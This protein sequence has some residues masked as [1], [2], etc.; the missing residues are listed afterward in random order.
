M[1]DL[2]V[3]VPDHCLSFY[4]VLCNW[5]CNVVAAVLIQY[6]FTIMH[7]S[8]WFHKCCYFFY[9][10]KLII[11][12]ALTVYLHQIRINR[13]TICHERAILCFMNFI[14]CILGRHLSQTLRVNSC[15]Y[16]NFSSTR[17]KITIHCRPQPYLTHTEFWDV[18]RTFK[19][20]PI[21]NRH[22]YIV[23]IDSLLSRR[24]MRVL[25]LGY[26]SLILT[27]PVQSCFYPV[28]T[29]ADHLTC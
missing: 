3:S 5:L 16:S 7:D 19:C 15:N 21:P 27:K 2:I 8:I 1:W 6:L 17:Q 26:D 4:F 11:H 23:S 13:S 29:W 20:F 28:R 12:H 18:E 24:C 10:S 25:A 9:L 22:R 14:G